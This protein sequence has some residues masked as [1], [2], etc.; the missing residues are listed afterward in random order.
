MILFYNELTKIIFSLFLAVIILFLSFRLSTHNPDTEKVSAYEWGLN[1]YSFPGE[2]FW[3]KNKQ[4]IT[5]F[6]L[7]LTIVLVSTGF[8]YVTCII[9]IKI[10]IFKLRDQISEIK[11]L[12]VL[13]D[14]HAL[15]LERSMEQAA[16]NKIIAAAIGLAILTVIGLLF[17]FFSGG[18]PGGS[19]I[20]SDSFTP[21][22]SEG[23]LSRSHS[24]TD[25]GGKDTQSINGDSIPI[26]T[27]D[28]APPT[29]EVTVV[30]TT[31]LEL[32]EPLNKELAGT[33]D[34]I[35][36]ILYPNVAIWDIISKKDLFEQSPTV[37]VGSVLQDWLDQLKED[38]SNLQG[39]ENSTETLRSI[40]L[41]LNSID[42]NLPPFIKQVNIF[43]KE[44]N[45][46]QSASRLESDYSYVLEARDA[47][48][49]LTKILLEHESL[50]NQ[51]LLV[52]NGNILVPEWFGGLIGFY[53]FL[54]V[55]SN[56]YSNDLPNYLVGVGALIEVSIVS[57]KDLPLKNT[58]F[59]RI[60]L[61]FRYV[62]RFASNYD[63]RLGGGA[64]LS[65][66]EQGHDL[67]EQTSSRV[68][69]NLLKIISKY[70]DCFSID[71]SDIFLF[72]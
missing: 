9:K 46:N 61:V 49:E 40:E 25:L 3:S 72:L 63:N 47:A 16:N 52:G 66:M 32:A 35:Y 44:A 17:F 10:L 8:Y 21:R 48:F 36:S 6:C 64:F 29:P 19:S 20:P 27:N 34:Q 55:V 65:V 45:L 11:N 30:E 38:Y 13:L 41:T 60:E 62:S 1:S 31:I 33:F 14:N 28:L 12:I 68:F 2:F 24:S 67:E 53:S 26:S 71:P 43:L 42:L 57:D 7:F 15:I 70:R 4:K 54:N 56:L 39:V 69:S 50:L 18:G 58:L 59:E 22:G 51:M 23:S 37:K 5:D